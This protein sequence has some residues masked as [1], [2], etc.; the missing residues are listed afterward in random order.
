MREPRWLPVPL[1][2][3]LFLVMRVWC[4]AFGHQWVYYGRQRVCIDCGTM[5]KRKLGEWES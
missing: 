5:Q 1:S 3:L 4:W 2:Y